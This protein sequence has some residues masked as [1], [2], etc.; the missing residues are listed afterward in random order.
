MPKT[1]SGKKLVRILCR[2]WG[3]VSVS[4]RGSHIKLKFCDKNKDIVVIVP[5]HS[6]LARGT[7][8]GIL[9]QARIGE[10]EIR[11]YF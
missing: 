5:L 1:I 9:K 4:Q 6:E 7:L 11:G 3:F 8:K 2:Y 10:K